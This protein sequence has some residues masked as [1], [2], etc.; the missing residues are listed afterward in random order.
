MQ[1]RFGHGISINFSFVVPIVI[2]IVPDRIPIV[3]MLS[4]SVLFKRGRESAHYNTVVPRCNT[5]PSMEE[6]SRVFS[7]RLGRARGNRV[8]NVL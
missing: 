1:N 3:V 6:K 7:V 5:N 2:T 8:E 4:Y